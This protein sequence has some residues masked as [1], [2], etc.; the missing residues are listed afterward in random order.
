MKIIGNRYKKTNNHPVGTG[1]NAKVFKIIDSKGEFKGDLV[2]KM[3]QDLRPVT[4]ERFKREIKTLMENNDV[5][6]VMPILD[7]DLD[8]SEKWYVM[9][10]MDVFDY[11]YTKKIICH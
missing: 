11:D 7:N 10:Q 5:E 1:A 8:G 4:K 2:V 6:G 9:P 3:L